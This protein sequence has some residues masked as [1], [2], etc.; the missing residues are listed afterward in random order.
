MARLEEIDAEA[1]RRSTALFPFPA[2]AAML[3]GDVRQI[4][5]AMPRRFATADP[6]RSRRP[7]GRRPDDLF[8]NQAAVPLEEE[9]VTAAGDLPPLRATPRPAD[10]PSVVPTWALWMLTGVVLVGESPLRWNYWGKKVDS[11]VN[12]RTGLIG[13]LG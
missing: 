4:P 12:R 6:R 13:W 11:I 8:T 5:P 3:A 1:V 10:L 2:N 9:E 7:G